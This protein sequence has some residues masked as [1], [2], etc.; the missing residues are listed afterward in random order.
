[1][2]TG[3]LSELD[4]IGD[5][6]GCDELLVAL[7]NRL[8]YRDHGGV[9][10]HAS[11]RAVFV[12]DLIDR[13]PGQLEVLAIVR[14]MRAAGTAMVAMGNHEW[15]AIGWVTRRDDDPN[16]FLRTHSDVHQRQ[17][18]AFLEQVGEGS[19]LHDELIAWFSTLPLW[20]DLPGLRVVHA[21]WNISAQKKVLEVTG[22]VNGVTPELVQRGQ[23]KPEGFTP[24]DGVRPMSAYD[25]CETLLKGL[26]IGLPG[27][28]SFVDKD[29]KRRHEARIQW[30]MEGRR[31]FRNAAMVEGDEVREA[32]P[33]EEL[34][35]P[36]AVPSDD[37]GR[38]IVFGHYWYR[39][40]MVLQGRRAV[41]VD[42]SAV[43]GGRLVAYRWS[44]EPEL[45]AANLVAVGP[46]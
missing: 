16:Q 41:C 46:A 12:G 22:G 37:D 7:L 4:V 1:M 6:H 21:C 20:I 26:E 2:E 10:G 45:D 14:A 28:A 39:G 18:H 19:A 34:P 24:W 3:T 44:G 23:R 30:W 13:G 38:P 31:T 15:N 17:H 11:R 33:D 27:G 43:L 32:M 5:V 40:P 42:H 9:W 36:F 29:G 8:G 35:G 25:A